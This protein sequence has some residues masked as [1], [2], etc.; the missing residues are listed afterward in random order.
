MKYQFEGQDILAPLT[1]ASNEPMFDVD[2]ISLQKQ[3]ASQNV[4]RWELSFETASNDVTDLLAA[5]GN[6]DTVKTMPMI[7]LQTVNDRLGT[8]NFPKGA[9][10]TGSNGKVYM[11]KEDASSVLAN[12]LYPTPP[13]G[14]TYST[15]ANAVISYYRDIDD[16]RG[17]T[18]QDGILASSGTVT[19]IEAI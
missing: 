12:N 5:V 6:F 15:V 8:V 2:T 4:Q 10:V 13:S 1:I 16:L 9:F 17:V 18:F 7:Q 11:V 19:I 14:L 3:R